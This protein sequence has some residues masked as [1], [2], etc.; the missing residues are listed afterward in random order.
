MSQQQPAVRRPLGLVAALVFLGGVTGWMTFRYDPEPLPERQGRLVYS[1]D[2]ERAEIGADWHQGAP[3]PGWKAG[4][5]RIEGGRLR[6]D[7]IHNAALWLQRPM[8]EKVRVEFDAR[9]ESDTGDVK[10]EIFGDGRTH[11]SGYILIMGGWSNSVITI[12]R[13]D[14][15]A[16][17]RKQDNRCRRTPDQRSVCVEPGVD[18][19]WAIERTDGVVRWYVDGQLL[20]TYDDADPVRGRHFAFNNWEAPVTFD[21]LAIYDLGE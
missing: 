10:C 9:A 13:Q 2:F 11:Q 3:D 12:A 8:P 1:D 7:N 15:H 21:N 18:Y 4:T 16:E 20:L 6:G 5:W 19:R 17:E 14:E